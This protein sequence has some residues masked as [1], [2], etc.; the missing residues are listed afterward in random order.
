MSLGNLYKYSASR[1]WCILLLYSVLLLTSYRITLSLWI[2]IDALG[3]C[4]SYLASY[5]IFLP[6]ISSHHGLSSWLIHY[7][8]VLPCFRCIIYILEALTSV[9]YKKYEDIRSMYPFTPDS[10]STPS[11]RLTLNMN[12]FTLLYIPD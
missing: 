5:C 2:N 3:Y 10:R 12:G 4:L 6:E 7:G 11:I 1:N 8:F 9:M